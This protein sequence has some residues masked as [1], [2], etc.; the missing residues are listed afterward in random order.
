MDLF[1]EVN[2]LVVQQGE[3][4]NGSWCNFEMKLA[5]MKC[6]KMLYTWSSAIFFVV[7]NFFFI[8]VFSL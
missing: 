5:Q 4:P 1:S 6:L 2:F 7:T 3:E 8:S